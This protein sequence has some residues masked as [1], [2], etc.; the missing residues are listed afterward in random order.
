VARDADKLTLRAVAGADRTRALRAS[1][2]NRAQDPQPDFLDRG[3]LVAAN[4]AAAGYYARQYPASWAPAYLDTR[5][6]TSM[7]DDPTGRVGYA[8]PGWTHVTEHLRG[9]GFTDAEILGAGLG[10]RASTGR[11]IDRFRDRLMFPIHARTE[12]GGREVVGFVGRRNPS[13]DASTDIRNPKYLNT[14]HTPLYTK[15]EHLYGL[16]AN[17]AVLDRGGLAVLVEGPIDALAVDLASGGMMAGLAPLGTALTDH[18]AG[19][20]ADALGAA[21]DR[22][23]IATDAD[24]AGVQAASLA[25]ELLTAHGLDPRGAALPEGMDPAQLGELHGPAALLDRLATAEPIGRQLVDHALTGRDL[26]W[27]ED[28]VAAARIAA[29]ILAKAPLDTWQRELT[30]VTARPGLPA[31]LLH[32]V[33]AER[34]GVPDADADALGRLTGRDRREDLDRGQHIRATA[35]QLAAMST[36]RSAVIRPAT[37]RPADDARPAH[38]VTASQARGRR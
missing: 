23:V 34:I 30:A 24:P 15:G 8:P 22:I 5:L 6:G 18:Q 28:R 27:P 32:T 9:N 7:L 11:V 13:L 37:A 4:S 35:A 19:Q 3:R 20:L 17:A 31:D 12:D 1:A 29:G 38:R 2:E 33:L 36:P 21:P 25:Y 10:T 14:G 16:A 26:T